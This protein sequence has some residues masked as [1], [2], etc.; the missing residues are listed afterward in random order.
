MWL[1]ARPSG[2]HR[3]CNPPSLPRVQAVQHHVLQLARLCG[4]TPGWP[5]LTRAELAEATM[6]L[7][8]SRWEA[9]ASMAGM[10]SNDVSGDQSDAK[11]EGA[12]KGRVLEPRGFAPGREEEGEDAT[13]PV[14][15]AAGE[16]W[17]LYAAVGAMA[18][19]GQPRW[20]ETVRAGPTRGSTHGGPG[21]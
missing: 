20:M 8:K 9:R 2:S 1:G 21:H 18:Q 4:V 11:C 15:I 5:V 16:A 10:D 13:H 17:A 19:L 12:R 6:R 14:S 3:V 7:A